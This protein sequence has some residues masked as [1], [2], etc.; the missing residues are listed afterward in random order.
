MTATGVALKLGLRLSLYRAARLAVPVDEVRH[1]ESLGYHSVW[2]AEAYGSDALTPLA[3]LAAHTERIRLGTAVVQLAA[4]PPATLAMQAMTIDALAGGNRVILGVGLSGPQIVEGWYGQ[5]WGRPNARLRDYVTI[6]RKVLAREEP[7][8]HDGREIRLPYTGPGALGQG[9]P[10]KSIM[11]PVA[12]VPIWLGAGGPRNTALAAEL[13]DGWLPMGLPAD[14][15]PA[16]ARERVEHGGFEIFTG[17]SVTI[18]DDVRGTL[19]AMRPL[20]AMYVGGMG[21]ETHNY[22]RDAMARRGFPEAADRVVELWRSGRRT[23]AM[24]AV[25]DDYLEQSALVG[26]PARIRRRWA[27]GYVPPGVTGLIVD[28]RQPEALE[29]MADLAGTREGTAP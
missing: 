28:A 29:L 16:P 14:G 7:V 24:A 3:Y 23:E 20:T 19:D 9:K 12:P 4:R 26:S 5:P 25:P 13:C 22:H 15:V 6:V 27:A 11:H 1:A 10:L 2:T 8:A 21:S 17:A 18:T